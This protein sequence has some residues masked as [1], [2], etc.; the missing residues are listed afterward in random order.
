MSFSIGFIGVFVFFFILG[1]IFLKFQNE[2]PIDS[3]PKETHALVTPEYVQHQFITKKNDFTPEI[4]PSF[5]ETSPDEDQKIQAYYNEFDPEFFHNYSTI[6]RDKAVF[7]LSSKEDHQSKNVV[8]TGDERTGYPHWLGNENIF[9]TAF[10]GTGCEGLY[11][12]NVFS[13]KTLQGG[14]AYLF[15]DNG[16]LYTIF[17]DWFGKNFRFPGFVSDMHADMKGEK[18]YLVFEMEGDDHQVLPEKRF[19]FTGNSLKMV[20]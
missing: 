17:S 14:L 18:T 13:R 10:C 4:N 3:K 15:D 2:T 19:L 16:G 7:L 6:A 11:L 5:E 9:F 8:F 12:V 1:N 20:N